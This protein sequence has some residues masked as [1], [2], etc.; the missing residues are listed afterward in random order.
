MGGWRG[1]MG[2]GARAISTLRQGHFP[3]SP[4]LGSERR[5]RVT[6]GLQLRRTLS[7]GSLAG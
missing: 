3:L 1:A 2:P 4:Q 7:R 6:L 5:P